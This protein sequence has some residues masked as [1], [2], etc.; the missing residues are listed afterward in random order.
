VNWFVEECRREWKRL[1]VADQVADEMAADLAADLEEAQAEGATAED[2]LGRAARDPRSFAA[3][4]AAARGLIERP[5]T[6]RNLPWIP[7]AIAVL[8]LIAI[9]GAVLLTRA[10]APE[11]RDVSLPHSALLTR[12]SGPEARIVVV[13]APSAETQLANGPVWVSTDEV[14]SLTRV[15]PSS[16]SDTRTIGAVLSIVS[17]VGI[18]L[19]AIASSWLARGRR[20]RRPSG[21]S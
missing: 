15:T 9:V 19:L 3:A 17:L 20:S 18:A 1:R 10:S 16:S 8:A 21:A 14:G 11:G 7:A 5:T 4:W 2:V 12:V 13:S 6:G